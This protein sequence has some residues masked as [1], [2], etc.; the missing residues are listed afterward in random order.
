MSK[1]RTR[2]P[3]DQRQPENLYL[4]LL[5]DLGATYQRVFGADIAL[6]FLRNHRIPPKIVDRIVSHNPTRR[7]TVLERRKGMTNSGNNE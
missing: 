5:V 6:D 7:L 3:T 1:R 2:E 4:S